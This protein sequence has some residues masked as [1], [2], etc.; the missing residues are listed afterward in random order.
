[1]AVNGN[2]LVYTNE[3]CVGCNKCINACSCMGACVSAE[4]DGNGSSR[5]DVDGTRCIACGACM[6]A[7]EHNAREFN[8]DTERFFADLRAGEPISVLIAPAFL[9]NYPREYE[10]VLGGLKAAGVKRFISVSFGADITTWGYIKYITENNYLGGISQPCPAVVGYIERYMPELLPKL[11]PVQ[12]PMMCA[13]IYARKEM[14]VKEK[15]AFISPCIAKKMEIDDPNNKGYISYNVTFDHLMKY[16]H[17]HN[18]K[19]SP[20]SDEIEYGL[21]SIYPMPGGLKDNVFWLLGESVFIRQI[22]GEKRMYHFLQANKDRIKGKKTPFLFIDALNCESGCICGT[23]TDPEISETDDALYNLLHIRESVKNDKRKDAWSK[24]AT[25][26]Q[27]LAALNKQFAHLKLE[28]YL[29]KYTD[30]SGTCPIRKPMKEEIEKIYLDMDKVT[31]EDRSINCSCC[32]YDTCEDMAIAIAN[33]FNNKENCVHYLKHKVEKERAEARAMVEHE[34]GILDSQRNALLTTLNDVNDHFDTLRESIREM[35]EGNNNNAEESNSISADVTNVEVFCQNLDV[36]MGKI[37]ESLSELSG[38]NDKV[39]QIAS[40]TN[41]LALN[42]SIE[43]ARAGEAGKG[44][45]VVASQINQLA[46]SSRE[47][48]EGSSEN[49]T[50]IR[51]AIER[52]VADTKQLLEVVSGVNARTHNL[53]SSTQTISAA[54]SV[55]METVDQVSEELDQLAKQSDTMEEEMV[56]ESYE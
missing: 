42:A 33:G 40:Q 6:D 50:Q 45:S 48:A 46:A 54:T 5:I 8:D 39:V 28:D 7:C 25:P 1:M 12:S 35:A 18:I 17:Q 22:E 41:L 19:G 23:A 3:N 26:A 36:S 21:G 32:G 51:A 55:V 24:R 38:N 20:C 47:T 52:I 2:S 44:F 56:T 10:S 43:A 11:F 15:M 34:K 27:R 37:L 31:A 13:A 14:G 53:A 9:A 16:V 4:P 29:R 49:N 30:R